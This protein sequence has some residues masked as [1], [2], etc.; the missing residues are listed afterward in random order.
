MVRFFLSN[1]GGTTKRLIAEL[2]AP[3]NTPS[4][5]TKTFRDTVDNLVGLQLPNSNC[6]LYASTH[7]AEVFTIIVEKAGVPA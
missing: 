1:D 3:A 4:N 7:N 5:I 2:P 6:I